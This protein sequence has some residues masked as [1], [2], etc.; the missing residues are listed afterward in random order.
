MNRLLIAGLL[1]SIGA[2]AYAGSAKADMS[3]R[4]C[5]ENPD[6]PDCDA[7]G[8]NPD[9]DPG[10]DGDYG[11]D[12]PRYA[13]PPP[14]RVYGGGGGSCQGLGRGLRQFGYRDIRPT[15][16][17]G[18]YYEYRARQGRNLYIVKVRSNSGR[19]AGRQLLR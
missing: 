13:P 7:T 6:D 18:K 2:V 11:D 14:R 8:Y 9:P 3:N 15:D 10:Y 4:Y 16:C 12:E 1:L 17:D 19:V 5:Y